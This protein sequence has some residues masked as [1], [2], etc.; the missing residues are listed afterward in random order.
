MK[1][2]FEKF[3]QMDFTTW[4]SMVTV[5]I[6]A[7]VVRFLIEAKVWTIGGMIKN[8]ILSLFMAYLIVLYCSA[9]GF[10]GKTTALFVGVLTVQAVNLL[11][12]LGKLGEEF[13]KDPIKMFNKIRNSL[14]R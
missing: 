6:C 2:E 10:S 12:G 7:T 9:M 8:I 13:A 4:L 1:D 5:A 14:K 3:A 11:T